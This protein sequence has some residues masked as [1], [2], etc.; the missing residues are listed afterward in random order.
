MSASRPLATTAAV[1]S[2]MA[3][4]FS[5]R[6]VP[7][8]TSTWKSQVLA[9]RQMA[10]TLVASRAWKPG[11]FESDRPGRLVMPK[12]VR[13]SFGEKARICRVRAGIARLDIV[14]A[15]HV[16]L[17]GNQPLVL[18]REVDAVRLRAVAQR[19]VVER[20]AFARHRATSQ[21]VTSSPVLGSF[22]SFSVMPMASSSSRMRSA[23]LKFLAAR[24]ALRAAMRSLTATTR[25]RR[26]DLP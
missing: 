2:L 18:D 20:D 17:L 19:R 13:L 22:A 8:A 24:A 1:D 14:E 10:S 3:A 25:K 16:E 4:R 6:V 23:S 11:S 15:K 26:D 7:S 21:V 5:S 12:A 9:T